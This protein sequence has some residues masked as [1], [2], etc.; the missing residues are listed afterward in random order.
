METTLHKKHEER[1]FK[2]LGNEDSKVKKALEFV[3]EKHAG[4]F[5]KSGEPYVV[6]PV[7]V[8]IILAELGMDRDTVVAGLLH[9]VLE[10][11]ETTY[12]ELKE[13]FGKD[14]ADIVEGVTKL[15]KIHF[16]DVETQKAENYRKLILAFSKDLRVIFVKLADRLHN[17]KTLQFFPREKQVRIAKETLEVYVPI[18]NRL[19]LWRI[20]TELEDLCF[21]YLYPKEY[22]EVKNF[23]G[24]SRREL[25]DYLKR[26]FIPRLKEEL[27]KAGIQ[28]H[29]SYRPKHL[30]GIWQ[31]TLRKGIKLEDVHDILGV[32]V[33]VNTVQECYLVL[34]I[35]HSVFKPVPG[36]FDDYI[37]LPKPN[38]YQSLHT[39]VIGPKGRMVEVQIRTWEMHERAEKGI[40]AHW[41]YKE[42]K[43]VKDGGVYSWLKSLVESVQGSKN[44]QEL[45]ENLKLELF[46]EEVFVF[47]PKGDLLVLPKGATPVD[48]AYYI[49][50]EVGNHC[51]GAKVNGRIVP[52]NYKLQNG[53]MVEIITNPNKKPNQEWLNFVVTSK[54]K[55]RIKAVLKELEREKYI[56]IGKEKFE[57]YLQKLGIGREILLNKLTEETKA[58]T[59]E[60][61]YLLLGSGKLSKER[62]YSLFRKT[63][64]EKPPERVEDILHIDG[65]GNV[66]HTLAECCNPLPGEEVYGVISRGKGLVIHSKD[67]PNLKHLWSVST[68]KVIKV[69]WSKSQGLHP[70][71]LRLIVKD[72]MGILGEVTTTIAKSGANI[73]EARTKSLPSGQALMDFTLQVENYQS[74]LKVKE[75]LSGLEGVESVQRLMG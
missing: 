51:A 62:V 55:S 49:H 68:E 29:V 2:A 26:V 67:C 70:V 24:R 47:T 59:E 46:S 69:L 17:M 22:E 61:L 53:D 13:N 21:M 32:R 38:L 8:A 25:E 50:T 65:L 18:A 63:Q 28:A 3:E 66:L 37:S 31:K 54:A 19:G 9:D 56:Q 16:K 74:F 41:A 33:I 34:G 1:L 35:V 30:Y 75:A 7:E 6:H 71:R 48:F 42:G 36:K 27:K 4:Q 20:K 52:L 72:R 73:T 60:E 43:S 14:V 64:K 58:K 39:A 5:R 44:P 23:V 11:T 10:D 40:A 12:E 45:L 15:G 57:L